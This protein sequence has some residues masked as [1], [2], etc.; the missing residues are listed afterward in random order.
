M[1]R[2]FLKTLLFLSLFAFLSILKL[3]EYERWPSPSHAEELLYSWSGIYLIETGVPVSW[4]ALPYPKEKI[5]FDGVIGDPHGIFLPAQL[6]KPWLDEPPLYS[7][8]SGGVAH[9]F[10]DAKDVVLPTAH[11]R[12]PSVLTSLATMFLVFYVGKTFLGEKLGILAM[13]I[14]GT[15][16]IFVFG[17]RLS[18]PENIFALFVILSV[19]LINSYVKNPRWWFALLFGLIAAASGLMKPTGFFFAPIFIFYALQKRRWKDGITIFTLTVIGVLFFI[20]YGW[21]YDWELFKY[22]VRIQGGRFPGWTSL[23]HILTTPAYDIYTFFDGWYVFCFIFALIYILGRKKKE[24]QM[25]ILT[26]V[27]VYWLLV[28]VFSGTEQDLLPWYR[29]MIFPLL[30]LFGAL[31]IRSIY[32]NPTFLNIVFIGGLLLTSRYYL[33]N[34]FRPT[35]PPWNWRIFYLLLVAPSLLYMLWQKKWLMALSRVICVFIVVIGLYLNSRYVYNVFAIRCEMHDC[36]IG[37]SIRLS[38]VHIPFFWRFFV[39]EDLSKV[40]GIKKP[41]F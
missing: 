3:H 9:L 41:F 33:H 7:I 38:E 1:K 27:F 2:N 25:Q 24:P 34:D 40:Y 19:L 15:A 22:I 35:T 21:T 12:I 37:P 6:M 8:I 16:P 39:N 29:Y 5:V 10:H 13:C 26:M 18:V 23:S 20:A 14:Y 4:S 28:G 31:G 32:K 36:I 17:A 30:P 11:T